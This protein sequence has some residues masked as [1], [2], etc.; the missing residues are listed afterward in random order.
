MQK[1]DTYWGILFMEELQPVLYWLHRPVPAL[2]ASRY[3]RALHDLVYRWTTRDQKSCINLVTGTENLLRIFCFRSEFITCQRF[4]YC[5]KKFISALSDYEDYFKND[6]GFPVLL[7]QLDVEEK[8]NYPFKTLLDFY[9]EQFQILKNRLAGAHSEHAAWVRL[10]HALLVHLGELEA[11]GQFLEVGE[12]IQKPVYEL[13]SGFLGRG[14]SFSLPE[15]EGSDLEALQ[16]LCEQPWNE[17]KS[18]ST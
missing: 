11:A 16:S 18:V 15:G 12:K 2:S 1:E 17:I 13:I 9:C 10:V 8:L 7:D 6:L 14:V 5:R 3:F 4:G